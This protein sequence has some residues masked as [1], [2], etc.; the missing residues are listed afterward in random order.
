ME[1]CFVGNHRK[2]LEEKRIQVSTKTVDGK[3]ADGTEPEY[4]AQSALKISPTPP[5]MNAKEFQQWIDINANVQVVGK[6]IET[7]VT[8]ELVVGITAFD[9]KEK[10]QAN[11][12]EDKEPATMAAEMIKM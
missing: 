7:E 2:L 3:V 12:E 6:T 11:N 1:S 5:G 4:G 8:Q 10:K 9:S